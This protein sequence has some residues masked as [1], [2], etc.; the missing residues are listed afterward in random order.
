MVIRGDVNYVRIGE[1]SNIQ[2]GSVL[3][4]TYGT[5]PLVIGN[6][7]TVGHAVSLHGCTVEDETLIGIGATA[8][9]T[10]C[11]KHS[12]SAVTCIFGLN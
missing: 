8:V 5:H 6:R 1:E 4:V 2:D 3:H 9:A 7:V 11:K 12:G 10:G